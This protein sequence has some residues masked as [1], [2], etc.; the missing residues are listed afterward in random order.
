MR[1]D[2]ACAPVFARHETFHPRYGWVKKAYDAAALDP[3]SFN[4][5]HAVVTLGVGKNMVRSIRFW[6]LA[7][8]VLAQEKNPDGRTALAVPTVIG[9]TFF[10]D[11]GW[12]PFCELSDTL[13]LLH[14]WLIAPGSIAPVWWITFNEFPG[15]E[16]TDEQLE[17]FIT[18]RVRDWADPHPSSVKKDVSCLIRMYSSDA[19]TRAGFDDLIDCPTKE[20]RLLN[21]TSQKGVYR[22]GVG[23]KPTLSPSVAAFAC[24]DF[25]AR[26][27]ATAHTA[28]ISRLAS[29]P[30]GPG[31][32]FKLTEAALVHLL[33]EAAERHDEIQ[34][35]SRAGV[36]QLTLDEDPSVAGTEL[37]YDHYRQLRGTVRFP[38]T[39]LVAGPTASEPVRRTSDIAS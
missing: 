22:F 28:T 19:K 21:L 31:R 30:G 5:E 36:P 11:D 10:A 14:W 26:T 15:I 27:E 12:D 39:G 35:T 2:L 20:L 29:E 34:L 38:G 16:F 13:W 32:A 9:R 4:D 1:C 33:E 6:G 24:L 3:G 7:Y 37:L 8:R 17:Q 18:D 23:Q 25:M